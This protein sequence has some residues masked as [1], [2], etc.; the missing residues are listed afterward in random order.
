MG[1][2]DWDMDILGTIACFPPFVSVIACWETQHMLPLQENS[3]PLFLP[4]LP[5]LENDL[6]NLTSSV[7][8]L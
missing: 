3:P 2:W 6:S 8:L 5:K 1:S 4:L 7:E